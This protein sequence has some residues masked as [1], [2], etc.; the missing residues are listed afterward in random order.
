MKVGLRMEDALRRS[1][2]SVGVSKIAAGLRCIWPNSFWG[3]NKI[4]DIGLSLTKK[5]FGKQIFGECKHLF[6]FLYKCFLICVINLS[7]LIK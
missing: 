4:L 5:L 7:I 1:M 2:W 6:G 3:N